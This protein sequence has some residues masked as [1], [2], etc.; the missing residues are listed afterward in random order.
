MDVAGR[1][2]QVGIRS[3]T[4]GG[5]GKCP[6]GAVVDLATCRESSGSSQALWGSGRGLVCAEALC[7]ESGG[8]D[9]GDQTSSGL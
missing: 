3:L 9:G 6:A 7:E 2:L 5:R 8:Q 4:Q 1:I